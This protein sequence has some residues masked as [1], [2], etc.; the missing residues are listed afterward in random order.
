MPRTATSD[1]MAQIAGREIRRTRTAV[2]LTQAEVAERLEASPSYIT[3]V[4]A[5]RVNL[6]LGQLSRIAA[7]MGADVDIS[8]PLIEI[9]PSHVV[10]PGAVASA[11]RALSRTS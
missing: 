5:G 8:L 6:T 3:N 10:E 2:G 11:S 7:A 4:E 1:L 9:Q